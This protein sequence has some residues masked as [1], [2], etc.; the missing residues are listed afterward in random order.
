MYE[1]NVELVRQGQD[2][3]KNLKDLIVLNTEVMT[4]LTDD[5]RSNQYCPANRR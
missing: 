1:N 2:M 5:I 3:S 4:R